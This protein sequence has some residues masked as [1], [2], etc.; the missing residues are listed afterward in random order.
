MTYG[1]GSDARK[2]REI[3]SHFISTVFYILY[4]NCGLHE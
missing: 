1:Q 2:L 4:P 3:R